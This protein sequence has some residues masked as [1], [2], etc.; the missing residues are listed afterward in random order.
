MSSRFR[1]AYRQLTEQEK[2]LTTNIKV[3]AELLEEQFDVSPKGREISLA[4]TK[5]EESVM[6]AVK[7]IT[8]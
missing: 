2:V 1:K 8:G 5:L 3:L 4:Y 6:W 7:A